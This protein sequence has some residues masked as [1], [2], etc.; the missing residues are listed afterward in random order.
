MGIICCAQTDVGNV[1]KV[2]QDSVGYKRIFIEEEEAVI[3]VVCDGVGGLDCGELASLNTVK[4]LVDWFTYEFPQVILDGISNE[5]IQ[6]RLLHFISNQNEHIYEF[7]KEHRIKLGTTL[8]A[9]IIFRG[10]YY[11]IQLGDS[12]LYLVSDYIEQ[13]TEDH[14]LVQKEINQGLIT[15]EQ[16]RVDPRRNI[17]LQCLGGDIKAHPDFYFGDVH[18]NIV[19]ILCSDG[20]YHKIEEQELFDLFS[21]DECITEEIMSERVSFSVDL[22]K[23]RGEKDNISVLVLKV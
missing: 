18:E 17:L 4:A 12:R 7:G 8:T 22:V 21:F 11:A 20:F 2:N 19:F 10:K 1:K 6:Q 14:S 15:K 9:V 3:A 16:G 23:K 5:L 13:I